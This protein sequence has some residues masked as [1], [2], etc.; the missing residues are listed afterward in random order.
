MS[1]AD[2]ATVVI[3][4]PSCGTR[5]QVPYGTVGKAGREVQCAQCGKPWHATADEPVPPPIDPD[6]MFTPDDEAALD[7]AFEHEAGAA[8][9]KP[10]AMAA[11]AEREKTLA[12]IRAA[13]AP[14]PKPAPATVDPGLAKA[15]RSFDRRQ[16]Q[17]I[18]RLPF[19][20]F[21]RTARL[22]AL[23]ALLSLLL[24]G[25]SLRV[26]VVQAFPSLAGLYASIGLPVNITGLEFTD[27]KTLKTL[28]EGKTVMTISA[29]IRSIAGQTVAVPPVLVSLLNDAGVTLYEWTAAPQA[30]D[31][32]PGEMLDF[33]TEV[34]SPPEGS[35][36]VRLSFTT[37]R[38]SAAAS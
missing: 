21:R 15:K 1:S 26:D 29:R 20:R 17:V 13:I 9:P 24:L 31:M 37:A 11:E 7:K 28:R 5:Y 19:A 4:C 6:M 35:T 18:S 23:V 10:L 34:N 8:A 2:L 22:A 14:K 36:R 38:G 32:E 3:A 12:E 16:R 25:F 30:P 33:S 27:A